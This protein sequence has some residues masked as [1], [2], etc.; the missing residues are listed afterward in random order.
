MA[1]IRPF[2]ALRPASEVASRVASVPY[3]VVSRDEAQALSR[4]EPLSFLHVSRAEVDLSASTNPYADEV[5]AKA[6]DNFRVLAR[7]A[8]FVR[9]AEPA[10]YVYRLTAGGHSQTGVAAS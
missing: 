9:D 5:Y 3:D 4:D 8:P 1:V 6:T 2:R 7:D 10:F